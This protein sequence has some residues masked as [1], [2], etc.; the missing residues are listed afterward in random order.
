MTLEDKRRK[1]EALLASWGRVI[2]AFSGGVDST[3]LAK[4][5]RDVLGK[6]QALAATADSPS[7]A[8]E[9]LAQARRL[10][11][12][13]DLEHRIIATTEVDRPDYQAN[14]ASRC[15][16]CKQTLFDALSRLARQ[17]KFRAVL[18]GVVADDALAER[19]GHQAALQYGVRAPLQEAG[20]TKEDVRR[21]ARALELPNWDKPQNA[22]LSSRVPH[23]APVTM[24][25][26]DQVERAEAWLRAQG[27]RQVRVRHLGAHAR[28]EVGP[29]EV[30]R[31]HEA[32]LRLAAAGAFER[33]GFRSVGI[34]RSGY[35]R[36][37]ADVQDADEVQLEEIA[38]C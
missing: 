17:L 23:G 11:R 28:I 10:A 32:A 6:P 9:D 35:R 21:L 20:F 16:I 33:I 18:Y 25:K 27:F 2:V 4:L 14:S 34:S 22:C 5:A 36:G 26:L 31:F 8:R 29:Q 7:L 30:T 1:A 19:P 15:F 12:T 13:L 24:E 38:T 3:L 37:G